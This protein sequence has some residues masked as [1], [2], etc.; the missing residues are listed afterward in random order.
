MPEPI[1]LLMV[2]FINYVE[3]EL[4]H[5]HSWEEQLLNPNHYQQQILFA[6]QRRVAIRLTWGASVLR[7]PQH[8]AVD[9]LEV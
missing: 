2:D 1:P 8:Y 4:L 3:V 9:P 6:L 5:F 7:P